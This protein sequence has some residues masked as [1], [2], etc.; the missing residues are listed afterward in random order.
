[1]DRDTEYGDNGDMTTDLESII[2][3]NYF[4]SEKPQE[5]PQE[6]SSLNKLQST[7]PKSEDKKTQEF[8]DAYRATKKSF[9][10]KENEVDFKNLSYNDL[11][12]EK[13]KLNNLIK[14]SDNMIKYN[15]DFNKINEDVKKQF[16]I[17]N[18]EI[19][20]EKKIKK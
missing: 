20:N 4:S 16:E 12:I 15:E 6:F 1:M 8:F 7:Y 10:F 13:N 19:K 5:K 17:I 3:N 18:H 9:D 11:K 14:S 2:D